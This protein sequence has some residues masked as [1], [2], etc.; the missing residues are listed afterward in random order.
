[1]PPSCLGRHRGRFRYPLDSKKRAGDRECWQL[2][3]RCCRMSRH[4]RVIWRTGQPRLR[5]PGL[6]DLCYLVSVIHFD[7]VLNTA[8]F[9]TRRP[10]LINMS[11]TCVCKPHTHAA[12]P[13]DST[14]R[15]LAIHMHTD[16]MSRNIPC[17]IGFTIP[18]KG[19]LKS[20]S[21]ED[22]ACPPHDSALRVQD[23]WDG[24]D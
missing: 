10:C 20:E 12:K 17:S 24:R 22:L 1:M 15:S 3:C 5:H 9:A 4:E 16:R 2:R 6:S 14:S 21:G 11:S 23:T 19:H 7:S 13:R 18:S 8:V